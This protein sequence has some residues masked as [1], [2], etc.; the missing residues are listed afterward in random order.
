MVMALAPYAIVLGVIG[1]IGIAIFAMWERAERFLERFA[2]SFEVQIERADLRISAQRIG[3]VIAMITAILWLSCIVV[4]RPDVI[5]AILVL[6]IAFAAS[7]MGFRMWISAKINRRLKSFNN[8]LELVLRL[9]SSGLRVGLSLRQALVLVTEES[10]EPSRTEFARIL[11]RT[12]IGISLDTALEDLVRRVP[13]EELEMLVDAIQVQSKT[14]GNLAKI[15]DHLAATIKARRQIQRKVRALTGEAK[16]SGWVIGL[17]PILVGSFIMA[18]QPQ[19]RDALFGTP[20]GHFSL[21]AF[22]VLEVV[23]AVA[24]RHMMKL[25]V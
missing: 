6:P 25:E 2:G 9:I 23:G 3:A 12:N 11:G 20:I 10:P 16:M 1:T 13:S 22:F 19:M 5:R 4:V 17:L 18:T 21:I 7:T 15:L 8:Q 14:G 24:V